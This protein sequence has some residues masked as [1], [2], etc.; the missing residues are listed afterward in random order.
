M[1]YLNFNVTIYHASAMMTQEMIIE[2]SE[3]YSTPT[4]R[5][6]DIM[7]FKGEIVGDFTF[8]QRIQSVQVRI[9]H[10]IMRIS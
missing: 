8:R 4:F 1:N 2:K 10:S 7:C 5:I 3:G 6:F 9:F